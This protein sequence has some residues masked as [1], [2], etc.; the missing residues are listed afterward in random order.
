MRPQ[1]SLL[2]RRDGMLADG[3]M[4]I[5]PVNHAFSAEA[6]SGKVVPEYCE[7]AKR[8]HRCEHGNETRTKNHRRQINHLSDAADARRRIKRRANLVVDVA[9][10][11]FFQSEQ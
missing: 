6:E 1:I 8:W 10:A 4:A 2:H 5:E 3:R 7:A 11:E 9:R